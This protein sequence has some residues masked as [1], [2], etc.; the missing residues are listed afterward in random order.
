MEA[1]VDGELLRVRVAE[2]AAPADPHVWRLR[3]Q[4]TFLVTALRD[5]LAALG[6]A[7]LANLLARGEVG[8]VP[9][10]VTPPPGLLPAQQDTY[11]A[12]LGSGLWLVW[13]PPG[14]GKTRVLR[15]AISDLIAA[16]K[17]VLL[18][19]STNIAVDNALHGVLRERRHQPGEIVRVGPPQLRE[20]ADD[21]QVCLPLMVRARLAEV[22][23]QRRAVAMDLREMDRREERLRDLD[24][25][26]AGFDAAA[27]EEA[28]ALLAG[29]GCT[30]VETGS[31]LAQCELLA[32]NG[33]RAIGDAR[34]DLEAASTAVT[35]AAPAQA[36]W[37]EIDSKEAELARVEEAAMQAEARALVAENAYLTAQEEITALHQPDGKVRWRDRRSLREAQDRLDAVRPEYD[38]LRTAAAQARSIATAFRQGTETAVADLSARAMLSREEVQRR[39]TAAEQAQARLD[40]LEQAQFDTLDRLAGLRADHTAAQ[41]AEELVTACTRRGWP[42]MHAQATTLRKEVVQDNVQRRTLEERHKRLQQQYERL[43]RDAQGEIIRAARLVAT[44][45]ARFRTT[46]AVLEGPYDVVLIDEVGAATLPEV[47][48]A[49]AKASRCAVLLGDFMQLGPVL[50]RAL[51]Y[52]DRADIRRWLMTDAFRHC[53][54]TAPAEALDHPSCLVLDTQHRFGPHI[55]Q[56]ANLLAYDGLLKPGDSV[57]SHVDGDPEIVLIDTDGLHELAQVRRV[58]RNAGWWPAGLLLAR[59]LVELHHQNGETTGVITPYTVQAEATLEALRDVEPGGRPLAE[60]GTAHRF[61]GREFPIVVF[62]TVEPWH[63]GG[64]WMGQASRLPGSNTWQQDGVR[65]FNVATTRVQHRLYVIASRDRVR[66]A[67]PG[68]AFGH[69]SELLRDHKARRVPATSLVTPPEF[70][71]A[72][73]GRKEGASRRCLPGMSKSPISTMS[74][75]STTSLPASSPR[76]RTRSGCGR[77]GSPPASVPFC[78]FSRK[79]STA[80][81]GLLSSSGTPATPSR[82]KGTSP[83]P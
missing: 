3:Q 55:M 9:A 58:S 42:S 13:G 5:E 39:G 50:P 25:R 30:A 52:S 62:D 12:C 20:I 22:E 19:S 53:G 73:L 21:P 78:R 56:L 71:P 49:I 64:L 47:L 2:F 40:G 23:K 17:R 68:T 83:K 43:S 36:L 79:R 66:N 70:E 65:L 51:N 37:A 26:L 60:V 28:T 7:G 24:A 75:R 10:A 57:R 11:R 54:I 29:P 77:P 18:V 14:T 32:E 34:R 48:L 76:P 81:C 41:V 44:T 33:L 31:A 69:L 72:N 82:R 6:D 4:P 16:G 45:L 63:D 46:K 61:Q 59:A 38:R 80:A 67:K 15:A 27:Y 35:E 1:T 74:V 8:G